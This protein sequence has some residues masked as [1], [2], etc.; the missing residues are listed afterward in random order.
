MS[1]PDLTLVSMIT[2]KTY[3]CRLD[4]LFVELIMWAQASRD[5][6]DIKKEKKK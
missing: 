4:R 3:A 5:T 2:S 6:I 1:S